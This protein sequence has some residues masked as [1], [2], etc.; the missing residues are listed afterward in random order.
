[1]NRRRQLLGLVLLLLALAYLLG[2][3]P[4]V[5][6]AFLARGLTGLF[7]RPATVGSVRFHW[8]SLEA[9]IEDVRVG[10]IV[11]DGPPFL[12]VPKVFVTPSLAPLWGRQIVLSSVR[13][14]GLRIRV[15]AFPEGG[16]DIP[17]IGQEGG[18][19]LDV[20]IQRLVIERGEVSLNHARVPLDLDLPDFHG[21]LTGRRAGGLAGAVSFEAGSLRFG[22]APPLPVATDI[23]VLL[24]GPRLIVESARL[25]AQGTDLV[26]RG[27]LRLGDP[28][29]GEF[30]LSGPVDLEMLDRHV[31]RTGFGVRGAGRW[32]GTVNV[33]GSKLR[34]S[35]RLEGTE[36]VFDEVAVPHYA[37]DVAWDGDGVHIRK[38]EVE[39]LGGTGTL[40][41]D[42]PPGPRGQSRTSLRATLSGVDAESLVRA[43]FDFGSASLGAAATGE[44][45]LSWP[46]GRRGDLSGTMALDLAARPEAKTPLSGRFEWKAENGVQTV[47]RADL[48]MPDTQVRLEGRVRRDGGA[49]LAVE[50]DSSD[51]ASSDELGVRVRRALGNPEA[52]GAGFSGE[53]SFRGRWKGTLRAPLFEGR[54]S[55]RDV[56]YRGVV[57]GRAE[58]VGETDPE[59]VRS[60]SLVVRRAESELWL[61]GL[62]GIGDYGT[63]DA[64]DVKVRLTEWPAADFIKAFAWKLDA[65]AAISGEA[66]L[67]GRRSALSGSA[68]LTA[69][70][71]RV[72]GVPFSDLD[73]TA[74]LK[75]AVVAVSR[76]TARVGGG[77]LRLRG[78]VSDDGLYDG[79]L[80]ANG[81]PAETLLT[82]YAPESPLGGKLSGR[83]TLLGPLARPRMR[84]E[85]SS[86]R[87]FL[88]DEG[89][90]ALEAKVSAT[91][92]GA[93]ALDATCRSARVDLKIGGTVDAAAP[94]EGVL[95]LEARETSLDPFLRSF[96]STFPAPLGIV[97]SGGVLLRGP[98]ATPGALDAEASVPELLL[99]LP[100][101]PIRNRD[102]ISVRVSGARVDVGRMRLAGEGTDLV[103]EG[104]AGLLPDGRFDLSATGAADLRTLS[105]FAFARR[106]RG[107]GA[108]RLALNVSGTRDAPRVDGALNLEGG[109]LRVRGFPHGLD[110]VRG[111]VRFSE[112]SAELK[113]LAGTLAGGPVE[114]DGQAAFA[115]GRVASFDV[116]AVGRR[117]ALRYPEGLRSLVDTDVRVFGDLDR[118]WVTGT[119]DVEQARWTRRYDVASE[120]LAVGG[121]KPIEAGTDEG[122]RYDLKIRAPGTLRVD[123]NLAALQAGAELKLQGS[124]GAPVLLGR[125]QVERGRV[126]FQGRTYVIRRGTIDFTNPQRTEPLFDIE[127]ETRVRSYRV[128]L[129]VN[130]T[131]TRVTPTLT[132][133]PPL[134]ALQILNL[135][136]GGD[137]S[138]VA[139]LTQA[140]TDQAR[141]AATGAASLAAGRISEG[142]GLERGAERLFGLNRFSIDPSVVKGGVTNPRLTVGKRITSDLSVLY[143]VD[144]RGTEER[145]LT[146]EYTLS[147]RF[148]LLLTRED[149]GGFG[150]DVRLR[151]SH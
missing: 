47:E 86:P 33:D 69:T 96:W 88:G 50:A 20:R 61:D 128:T 68:H 119:I 75:P 95:R 124:S 2:R 71:G 66:A 5:T 60:H 41:V 116:H 78:S 39:A 138:T 114:V 81:V 92:D 42:I 56:G 118:P 12:E 132:S 62:T 84:G 148:S 15:N 100:E 77:D 105:A 37:G 103:I 98:L 3:L 133:D 99:Q 117:L 44:L 149:P 140:Q 19:G 90:G 137:E 34:I 144:L 129:R 38:L 35:G 6:G 7:H 76:A 26:Y 13:L 106:L 83:L 40:D 130:G 45:S 87:L 70:Q 46:K 8:L 123:N 53:G 122:P 79:I 115:G 121:T 120:L 29:R 111:Q 142:V 147:D 16:D 31:M 57:W 146:V 74:R 1:L 17:K 125:A 64:L 21:R 48:R 23:Q 24:V 107:R 93:L 52:E 28:P 102:P 143:T 59:S 73:L 27:E 55:G 97:A 14:E 141:L 22:D 151:Q 127:A 110:D 72:F 80:E 89:L 85:I 51:L 54:F 94:H 108:A 49:D 32:Q 150:V 126:Y 82:A 43:V 131:L 134:S 109:G 136:A 113:K 101:Y 10:G 18:A 30:Q 36:G 11:P 145:I 67:T 104:S 65:E 139:S 58:W 25:R 4:N 112:T 9:E 63:E 135:L 91:G